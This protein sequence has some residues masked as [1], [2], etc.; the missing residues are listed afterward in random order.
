MFR[1]SV[2]R[3]DDGKGIGPA[4]PVELR[5]LP[6]LR[7]RARLGL[8]EQISNRALHWL[9]VFG[10]WAIRKV[11]TVELSN[12]RCQHDKRIHLARRHCAVGHVAFPSLGLGVPA[13]DPFT[14]VERLALSVNRGAVIKDAAIHW[15]HPG[16]LRIKPNAV[17]SICRITACSQVALLSVTAAVDPVA[18]SGATILAQLRES[19]HLLSRGEGRAVLFGHVSQ[20]TPVDLTRDTMGVSM[21][22]IVPG[23]IADRL[24]ECT[25]F[26][27]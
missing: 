15:P 1:H 19:R 25:V 16:P 17:R 18:A 14:R 11:R 10:E 20:K 3:A 6:D 21:V 9:V 8:R 2:G 24:R 26:L 12:A 5:R 13:D 27:V 22:A 7:A 23:E 4:V